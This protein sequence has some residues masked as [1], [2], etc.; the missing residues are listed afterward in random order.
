MKTKSLYWDAVYENSEIMTE[1]LYMKDAESNYIREFDARVTKQKDDYVVLDR[2]AFYPLGGGQLSDT[3]HLIWN[4]KEV[5][6]REVTKKGIIKHHI[7]GEMPDEGVEVK[8]VLDWDRRYGH[9]RMHTAQH[10]VSG[11]VYDEFGARTVGNQLY[12]DR[13]RVDFHPV[14]FTDEDLRL[15]ES[16][17]NEIISRSLKVSIYTEKRSVL[18]KKVY[19]Q[20]SNLDLLPKSI[21]NLRVI[22]ID[23]FDICPCAGTH[24]RNTD[25]LG[26]VKIIKKDNKGKDRVRITYTLE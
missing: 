21:E 19:E 20:R 8:G 4:G 12:H 1:V 14:K 23:G 18:E 7:D 9:M 17:A 13:A 26:K 6:V 15:I 11:V 24:V 10:I 22:D 25:E 16:L 2:S 5:R 3:G